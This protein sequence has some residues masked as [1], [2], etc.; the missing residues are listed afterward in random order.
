MTRPGWLV[1]LLMACAGPVPADGAPEKPAPVEAEGVARSAEPPWSWW[2]AKAGPQVAFEASFDF[3]K[4]LATRRRVR[5]FQGTMLFQRNGEDRAIRLDIR[6]KDGSLDNQVLVDGRRFWTLTAGD[7]P[8]LERIDLVKREGLRGALQSLV[9][10]FASTRQ[11]LE[12]TFEVSVTAAPDAQ[13]RW[14]C[15]LV[16]RRED[17]R[18]V[19][20]RIDMS[21]THDV[22]DVV[23]FTL[24]KEGEWMRFSLSK[25]EFRKL[26]ED[27]LEMVVP[28]GAEVTDIE[29][30]QELGDSEE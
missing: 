8:L 12:R 5:K 20:Q 7:P 15:R 17:D 26:R 4:K 24:P 19:L 3:E 30:D 27:E 16:P 14:S 23:T 11:E 22:L 29:D 25:M 10:F 2:D 18:R 1:L 13:G 28:E 6:N 21:L 9:M